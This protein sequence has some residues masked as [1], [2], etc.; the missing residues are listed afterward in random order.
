M[1]GQGDHFERD[2][3][4]DDPGIIGARWWNRALGDERSAVTRR[5]AVK[6]MGLVMGFGALAVGGTCVAGMVAAVSEDD[7]ETRNEASLAAQRRFGWNLGARGEPLT[8]AIETLNE[9]FDTAALAADL[10]PVTWRHVYQPTLLEAPDAVPRENPS[11]ETVPFAPLRAVLQAGLTPSARVSLEAGMALARIFQGRD[12]KTALVLDL[13]GPDSVAFA[14]GAAQV[15]EPVLAIGN[16]PHPRGVVP[17]H[18]TLATALKCHYYFHQARA[19]RPAGAPPCFVLDRLRLTETSTANLFDNRYLA[20]LPSA[21]TLRAGG[22]ERVLYVVPGES[23]YPE[24]DDLNEDF[25]AYQRAG[26]EVR[27]LSAGAFMRGM[28]GAVEYGGSPQVEAG[29]WLRYPWSPAAP[30]AEAPAIDAQSA[31]YRPGARVT[32]F[33]RRSVPAGFATVGLVVSGAVVLG[34]A[35]DRRGSWNRAGGG[36]GGG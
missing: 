10:T 31:M 15:F 33:S 22:V 3:T 16:W 27:G 18:L 28:D 8:F 35:F 25:L 32:R 5:D 34:A 20:S 12:A 30:G 4:V 26:I 29:F 2:V 6:N 24:L 23:Y 36:W 17:S 13:D 11:E 7:T 14:A 19:Q 9:P 1:T 21:A